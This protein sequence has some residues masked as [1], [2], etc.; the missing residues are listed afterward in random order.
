M[1]MTRL[2]GAVVLAVTTSAA[3]A[4]VLPSQSVRPA[5]AT[6]GADQTSVP[7]LEH[8]DA[9]LVDK[10]LDPCNDFYKYSCNKWLSANPIPADQVYWA[11]GSGLELWNEG[12]LR[13]TLEAASKNDPGRN[14]VQQKIG[15]YWAAC[16]DESGIE[17]AGLKPLE[18]ELARIA[19]LKS[20]KEL[21]AEIA[22]L[23][24]LYPGAW[25]PGD[26]QS[27]SAIFGFSGIQDYDNA[28]MVVAQ[29]DQGG[30]SLPTRDYYLKTDDKSKEILAKYRTHIQKMFV[31]AGE[32]E[33]QA[34]AD[35]GTVIELETAM[36][37]AQMDNV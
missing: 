34:G 28:A 18:P 4:Q 25:E 21:T 36:A 6:G 35:A 22:H 2:F 11:T 33:S 17:S 24:H 9:D 30:L 16:M 13:E 8:F 31:L 10:T 29:I 14:P 7:K 27:N 37:Q 3:F 26:N 5:Y 23:Q 19:A 12:I 15:D 1:S 32:S 20:K